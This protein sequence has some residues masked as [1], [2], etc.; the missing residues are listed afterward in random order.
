MSEAGLT[1][2]QLAGK[3]QS[4]AA[5]LGCGHT[6]VI[7]GIPLTFLY[8]ELSDDY[9]WET[10]NVPDA[11]LTSY[12]VLSKLF[13][14]ESIPE[15]WL[16]FLREVESEKAK[17]GT[18]YPSDL[19]A[20]VYLLL[21]EYP[22]AK[23][24]GINNFTAIEGIGPDLSNRDEIIKKVDSVLAD[25]VLRQGLLELMAVLIPHNSSHPAELVALERLIKISHGKKILID[26]GCGTGMQTEI[27][28][29]SDPDLMVVG[30]DRQYFHKWYH[31]RQISDRLQQEGEEDKGA[32]PQF[33]IAD[34]QTAPL[35]DDSVDFILLQAIAP[36]L[37][38]GAFALIL[39]QAQ[40][41]LKPESGVLV[42]GP[43]KYDM[44]ES[45]NG[46]WRYFVKSKLQGEEQLVQ[47]SYRSLLAK[48]TDQ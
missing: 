46:E 34:I 17:K 30:M 42:V 47:V 5:D 38:V 4:E 12:D 14:P 36:H 35:P 7:E 26:F 45:A 48:M 11:V 25:S 2:Q 24:K 40:R 27:M 37:N 21:D 23:E 18:N 41:I 16:A 32:T 3:I 43:Q 10:A 20:G 13:T 8:H 1:E 22:A 29:K 15:N 33:V 9:V 31:W 19:V 44:S 39:Q 28:A 6:V